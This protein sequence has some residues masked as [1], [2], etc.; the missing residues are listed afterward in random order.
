MDILSA[1]WATRF[2]NK[3]AAWAKECSKDPSSQV[4]AIIVSDDGAELSTGYNG[5]PRNVRD[6]PDRIEQR[7]EKY[8]WMAH[9]E[10]NAI[11]NAARHGVRLQGATMFVTHHPCSRCAGMIVN[12]GIHCVVVGDG[13]TK[14]PADEVEV[15]MLKFGDARIDFYKLE[16]LP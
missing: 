14:M 15:A 10:E 12:A 13:V 16:D 7:P 6:M 11:V 5:L 2:M 3:A 8:K 9:A 1:K 4:G